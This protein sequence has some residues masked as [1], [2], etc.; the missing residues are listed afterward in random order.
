M[1]FFETKL[2]QPSPAQNGDLISKIQD[3]LAKIE[4]K[5]EFAIAYS[6]YETLT[7]PANYHEHLKTITPQERDRYLAVKLQNY[8]YDIYL[9]FK[10]KQNSQPDIPSS[11]MANYVDKWSETKFYQR[12]TQANCGTGYRDPGWLVIGQQADRWQVTKSGLI[13]QIDSGQHLGDPTQ[14]LAIDQVV[15]LKLPHN[16]VDHGR[17]IAVGNAGLPGADNVTVAQI[18]FN[19]SAEGALL[20]LANLTQK[21]NSRQIS[22][23]FKIAYD[24]TDFERLDA[25]ILEFNSTDFAQLSSILK[26]IYESN[27]TYFQPNIPFFTKHLGWLGIGLAEKLHAKSDSEV[28]NIGQHHCGIIA[29]ALLSVWQE[30][31][32]NLHQLDYVL[33]YLLQRGVDTQYPYLNDNSSDIYHLA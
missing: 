12:L 14:K 3:T 10:P 8:L 27:H 22:F 29:Q 25:A 15:A 13:L 33:D 4:I 23:A 5:S 16:L 32:L 20:L 21:L 28:E 17:Y 2:A 26:E 30:N 24:E 19:V 6:G 7:I 1:V 9:N 11:Q 18:Y 31:K